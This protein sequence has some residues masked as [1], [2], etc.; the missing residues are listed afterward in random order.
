MI[1]IRVTAKKNLMTLWNFTLSTDELNKNMDIMP[2][3][4]RILLTVC[5]NCS[6]LTDYLCMF[7]DV[8]NVLTFSAHWD[9][10]YTKQEAHPPCTPKKSIP[11][12]TSAPCSTDLPT[13]HILKKSDIHS[14]SWFWLY[15]SLIGYFFLIYNFRSI[16][17]EHAFLLFIEVYLLT[18]NVI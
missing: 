18:H 5:Q 17:F 1:N 7:L 14:C 15:F 11:R 4:S 8:P 9:E 6:Y 16:E 3:L 2:L 12:R 10:T 13:Y